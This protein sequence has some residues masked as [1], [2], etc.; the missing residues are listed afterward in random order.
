MFLTD[1]H[2]G[3]GVIGDITT[4]KERGG[5]MG[6][7]GGSKLRK[8]N[9]LHEPHNVVQDV[10]LHPGTRAVPTPNAVPPS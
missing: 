5:F 3:A 1:F 9:P 8:T 6:S 7:F 4:A 2:L 10:A